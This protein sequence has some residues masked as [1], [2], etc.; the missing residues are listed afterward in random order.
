ML[1]SEKLQAGLDA[2][3]RGNFLVAINLLEECCQEYEVNT[4]EGNYREYISAQSNLIKAYIYAQKKPKAVARCEKL[5]VGENKAVRDW[6]KRVLSSISPDSLTSLPQKEDIT[7]TNFDKALW[8]PEEVAKW[9]RDINSLIQNND[10]TFAIQLL[11]QFCDGIELNSKEN[12]YAQ[13]LLVEAYH[14]ERR[15]DDAKALSRKLC[16]S[17]HY[18]THFLAQ[19]YFETSSLDIVDSKVSVDKNLLTLTQASNLFQTG[20]DALMSKNYPKAIKLLEEY[21]QTASPKNSE[22]LQANKWLIKAYQEQGQLESAIILCL[23]LLVCQHKPTRKWARELLYLE[24]FTEY[25]ELIEFD[26]EPVNFIET[27][28]SPD[29]KPGGISEQL[30]SDSF[31]AKTLITNVLR[32]KY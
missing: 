5:A 7:D 13:V 12:L 25:S 31:Q 28:I 19:H 10:N 18:I 32:Q 21:S 29:S 2:I 3:E 17:K 16:D 1:T 4:Q 15:F 11:E 26:S 27:N 20:Y 9:L 23:K 30:I 6:A 24:L 14:G 8:A 22:Y